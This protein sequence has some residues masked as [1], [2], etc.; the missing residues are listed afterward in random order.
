MWT[1]KYSCVVRVSRKADLC[2]SSAEKRHSAL[3]MDVSGCDGAEDA[4]KSWK[5]R[6]QS[7]RTWPTCSSSKKTSYRKL[8]NQSWRGR[9]KANNGWPYRSSSLQLTRIFSPVCLRLIVEPSFSGF[10][11]LSSGAVL[12]GGMG[13]AEAS[14]FLLS[15]EL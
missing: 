8:W 7:T 1:W 2:P 10:L 6:M 15:A 14:R 13:W 11:C 4:R 12:R 9:K 5:Q 3:R